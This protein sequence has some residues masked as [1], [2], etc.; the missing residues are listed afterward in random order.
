MQQVVSPRGEK[1]SSTSYAKRDDHTSLAILLRL[2]LWVRHITHTRLQRRRSHGIHNQR[3]CTINLF[4]PLLPGA[5][6]AA[7]DMLQS[8]S[9]LRD[10]LRRNTHFFRSEMAAAGF[11]LKGVDHP[12]VPVMLGDAKMA[13]EMAARLLEDQGVYVVAFSYPVVPRGQA[14]IRVQLSA[15]HTQEQLEHTVGAFKKVGAEMGV[16]PGK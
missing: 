10:T 1:R 6:L 14:R 2:Q 11:T 9:S 3:S 5:S 4:L 13:A 15:A 16:I 7:L 12:I 8:S